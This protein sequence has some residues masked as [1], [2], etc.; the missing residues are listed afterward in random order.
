M[1]DENKINK[2]NDFF[3]RLGVL[4]LARMIYRN[5]NFEKELQE[6]NYYFY[7]D[8]NKITDNGKSS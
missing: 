5:P 7:Q 4:A 3:N 6:A 2:T 1:P 8:K